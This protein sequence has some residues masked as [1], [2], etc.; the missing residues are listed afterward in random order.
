VAD[1]SSGC[2][3]VPKARAAGLEPSKL[4]KA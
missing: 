3:V 4:Q 1:L 2:S